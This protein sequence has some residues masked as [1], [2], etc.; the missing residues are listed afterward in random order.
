MAPGNRSEAG[1]AAPPLSHHQAWPY[2]GASQGA[3]KEEFGKSVLEAMQ[4]KRMREREG[5]R[6]EEKTKDAE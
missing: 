3:Q 4:G 6:E 5:G 1:P 2:P